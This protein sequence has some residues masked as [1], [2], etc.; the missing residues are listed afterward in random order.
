MFKDKAAGPLYALHTGYGLGS[1]VVPQL[2]RPFLDPRFSGGAIHTGYKST[3]RNNTHNTHNTT[4]TAQ[5]LLFNFESNLNTTA[6]SMP[7][8]RY[9]AKF[10]TAYWLLS[11]LSMSIAALFLSYHVHGRV[12][13]VR[14]DTKCDSSTTGPTRQTLK[15][16]L[17]PKTCSPTKP[18]YAVSIIAC[19]FFYYVLSVPQIRAFSKF[20]FSYA[21]DGPCLSVIESTSLESVYFATVTVGRLAAFLSSTVLH[22]KVILQVS[23]CSAH[24]RRTLCKG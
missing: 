18:P 12:S 8:P 9:P 4:T 16:S 20:V 14:I 19:L 2:V 17:S 23:I 15:Q 7:T 1:L 11:G 13:G 10:T 5:P 6:T 24:S 21:R 22:M 3:C